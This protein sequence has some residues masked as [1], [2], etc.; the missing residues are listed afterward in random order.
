MLRSSPVLWH[1]CHDL[2]QSGDQA[3]VVAIKRGEAKDWGVAVMDMQGC[4]GY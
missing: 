1:G 4:F 3:R 2:T